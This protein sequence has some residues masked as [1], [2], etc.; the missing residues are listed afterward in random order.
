MKQEQGIYL[1]LLAL[2]LVGLLAIIGFVIDIGTLER[3]QLQ[4]QKA[5]DAA[6]IAGLDYRIV[7]GIPANQGEEDEIENRTDTFIRQNLALR[8]FDLTAAR[9]NIT[10]PVYTKNDPSAAGNETLASTVTYDTPYLLMPLVPL[11]M[12]GLVNT[13]ASRSLTAVAKAVVPRANIIMVLDTSN[14]MSCPASDPDCAC[15]DPNLTTVGCDLGPKSGAAGNGAA[16]IFDL[17]RGVWDFLSHFRPGR[18]RIALV[19]FD[20]VAQ[21]V[22]PFD[23][24]G[25]NGTGAPDGLP[26]GFRVNDFINAIGRDDISGGALPASFTPGGLTNT[27]DGMLTAYQELTNAGL[28]NKEKIALVFFTDGAPTAKIGCYANAKGTLLAPA[29]SNDAA[30]PSPGKRY[31]DFEV[32]WVYPDKTRLRG[33]SPLIDKANL[34]TLPK[35]KRTPKKFL[36]KADGTEDTNIHPTCTHLAY[37]DALTPPTTATAWQQAYQGCLND[38][39]NYL[40]DGTIEEQGYPLNTAGTYPVQNFKKT[41]FHRA[42]EVS[43]FMQKHGVLFYSIGIGP[44]TAVGPLTD[45]YEGINDDFHRKDGFITLLSNDIQTAQNTMKP[46]TG[47]YPAFGYNGFNTWENRMVEDSPSGGYDKDGMYLA[48]YSTTGIE[49]LFSRIAHKI[50]LRFLQ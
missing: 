43:N 50:Q 45:I 37:P 24:T 7:Q 9:L 18:D 28:I 6:V 21:T 26:D 47:N 44:Q 36:L 17:R 2:L 5:V 14:S 33:P 42:I 48:G 40:P 46:Q 49:S 22:V 15:A 25:P 4:L 19:T 12:I 23:V 31:V 11:S 30:C 27:S 35:D 41:F 10:R 3:T 29:G 39:S 38:F 32:E 20:L 34:V 8:G 1:P 13:P 16:K